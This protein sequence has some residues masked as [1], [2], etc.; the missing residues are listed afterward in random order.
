MARTHFTTRVLPETK[1]CLEGVYAKE[2]KVQGKGRALD[3]AVEELKTTR[4]LFK[5]PAPPSKK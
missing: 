2:K 5:K 1:E 4:G 3:A